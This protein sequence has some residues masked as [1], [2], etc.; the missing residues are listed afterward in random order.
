MSVQICRHI[1]RHQ[2]RER[3]ERERLIAQRLFPDAAAMPI[4]RAFRGDQCESEARADRDAIERRALGRK[5]LKQPKG[6]SFNVPALREVLNK[7]HPNEAS[8]TS[9]IDHPK[10]PQSRLS[11]SFS[12]LAIAACILAL[13]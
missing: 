2:R 9:K 4:E 12:W 10:S 7:L 1:L 8:Q 13:N 3:R 5:M 6:S 11:S